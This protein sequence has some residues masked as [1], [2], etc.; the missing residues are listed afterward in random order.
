MAI[1][2]ECLGWPEHNN[3]EEIGAGNERDNKRKSEN[4]RL[5]LETR[6]EY[7]VVCPINFPEAKSNEQN[8]PNNQW[9]KDMS[10]CPFILDL[11]VN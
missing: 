10:R 7:G 3:G 4:A 8:E 11:N 1:N 6:G 9:G 2:I 5:L